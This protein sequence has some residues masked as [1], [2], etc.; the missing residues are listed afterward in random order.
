MNADDM[1]KEYDAVEE[2]EEDA[3]WNDQAWRK[4]RE[5][6]IHYIQRHKPPKS[7]FT[8]LNY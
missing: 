5:E 2:Q 6:K 1:M 3:Q 8:T 4:N 7:I